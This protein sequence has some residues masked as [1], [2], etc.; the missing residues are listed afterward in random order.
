MRRLG[1]R[2]QQLHRSVYVIAVLSVWHFWLV[3]AG[4]NDFF[5]PYVYAGVL[6]LLLGLRIIPR[7]KS[8]R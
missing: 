3:R 4:K 7:L 2:W 5:E 8:K 1:S 6:A